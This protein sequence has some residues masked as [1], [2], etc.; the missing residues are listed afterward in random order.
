[1]SANLTSRTIEKDTPG[2]SSLF[3][4]KAAYVAWE[5]RTAIHPE[6]ILL[7]TQALPT[8]SCRKLSRHRDAS[9]P[10]GTPADFQSC[11]CKPITRRV[12]AFKSSSTELVYYRLFQVSLNDRFVLRPWCC[13]ETTRF[14]P[15][16]ESR[17]RAS[18]G[19]SV[20]KWRAAATGREGELMVKCINDAKRRPPLERTP[21]QDFLA[22]SRS[23]RPGLVQKP[24]VS[25]AKMAM[26]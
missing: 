11:T 19:H 6:A 15:R 10:V 26:D 21:D 17:Q 4:C 2:D 23:K 18:W 5:R 8:Q 20:I 24:S 9:R 3:N 22:L 25:I 13:I 16:N 14:R 12:I 7:V 1:M